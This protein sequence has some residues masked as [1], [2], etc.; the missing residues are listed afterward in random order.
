MSREEILNRICAAVAEGEEDEALELV[1]E[2]FE[3]GLDPMVVLNEGAAKGMDIVSEQYSAGEAFLPELVLA[4]DA[5]GAV[6]KVIF[7]NMSTEEAQL[8]R[9]GIVV[10]GQAKGIM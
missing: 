10:I 4:G 2:A 3:M 7:E 9:K 1:R 8:S 6:V 5:M